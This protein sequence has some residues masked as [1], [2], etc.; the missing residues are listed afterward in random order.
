MDG[1]WGSSASNVW[2]L[3]NR[4]ISFGVGEYRVARFDGARWRIVDPG[5][6]GY[7]R[8][9]R[10]QRRRRHLDR[11]RARG[12]AATL[13]RRQLV[14]PRQSAENDVLSAIRADSAHDAWAVGWAGRAV[15]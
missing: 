2:G 15:R 4:S 14:G 10:R 13:E 6:G 3:V 8:A 11:R 5:G 7:F 9:L 12:A 1:M